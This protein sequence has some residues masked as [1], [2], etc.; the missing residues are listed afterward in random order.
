[1]NAMTDP[2]AALTYVRQRAGADEFRMTQ[3]ALQEM[4]EEAILL[5]DVLNAI[6]N[7]RILEDYPEHR[8]GPCCLL[9]GLDGAGRDL[10]IVC[11]TTGGVLIIITVYR[12]R[13]PKWISPTQRRAVP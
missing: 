9:H 4:A 3:H 11:T 1:M 6:G 5:A 12:P 13:P 7:A 8:R 10:H 2:N